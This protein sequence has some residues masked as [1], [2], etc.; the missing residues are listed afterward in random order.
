M[1]SIVHLGFLSNLNLLT[2]SKIMITHSSAICW[3]ADHKW[4]NVFCFLSSLP[5]LLQPPRQCLAPTCHRTI[6]LTNTVCGT[7]KEGPLSIESSLADRFH[8]ECSEHGLINY[9]DTRTKCRHLKKLTCNDPALWTIAPL[10][11]SLVHLPLHCEYTVPY[12]IYREWVAGRGR[13]M[14]SPV[15]DHILQEFSTL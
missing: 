14:L 4:I 7:K 8:F 10:T 12:R 5:L 13:G 11:F 2:M 3:I 9:K 15:G 1:I 6:L